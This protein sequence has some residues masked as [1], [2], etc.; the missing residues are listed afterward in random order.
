MRGL[1]RGG[2]IKTALILC[3]ITAMTLMGDY[4]IKLA[5]GKIGGLLSVQFMAG[6]LLYGITA[7]GWFFLMKTNSLAII[8]VL[9]S[10]STVILLAALGTLVFKEA[11]GWRDAIG[12]SLAVLAVAVIS[13]K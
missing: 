2:E 9:F 6:A 3:A 5:T 7:I 12:I 13:Y 11:F 8:G 4:C 1:T 10:A